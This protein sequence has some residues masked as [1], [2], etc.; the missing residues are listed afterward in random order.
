[1]KLLCD[2]QQLYDAFTAVSSAAPAKTPLPILQNVLL[3]AEGNSCTFFATDNEMSMRTSIGS[4]KV[5][6]PGSVLLPAKETSALLRELDEATV[7]LESKEFRCE[8]QSGSGSYILV[9]D[10]PDQFPT[11]PTIEDSAAIEM[12]S[13]A[14]I[15]MVQRTS[16]AAAREE[17][18][19]AING[20]LLDSKDGRLSVVGTDG[21]RLSVAFHHL[22]GEP[23]TKSVVVPNRALVALG[24]VIGD[25]DDQPIEIRIATSKIAFRVGELELISQLSDNRFPDYEAVIPKAADTTIEV[26]RALFERSL[27][28]VAILSSGDVRMVRVEFDG[29]RIEMSAEN[30]EVGRAQVSIDADIRGAGGVVAFNPDFLLDALKVTDS[31]IIRID[32]TDDSTPAKLALGES[33]TYV[34]MPISGS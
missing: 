9:G 2:R 7:A 4:V 12:P 13:G 6:E 3:R 32:L 28:R 25:E 11:P 31:E 24:R 34:L 26:D 5:D 14:F 8:I 21:R 1:M 33:H 16:F 20:L 17:T 18:R 15:E 23:M 30:T 10:D 29:G 22:E 19:Y 27:R